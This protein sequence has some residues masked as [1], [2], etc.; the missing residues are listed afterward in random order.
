MHALEQL[1]LLSRSQRDVD[2]G[3]E[4]DEEGERDNAEADEPEPVEV[5]RVVDVP[6]QL[7]RQKDRISMLVC[8][9][10]NSLSGIRDSPCIR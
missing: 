6:S 8:N 4:E 1:P 10:E 3:I 5:D 9:V 2:F 7:R